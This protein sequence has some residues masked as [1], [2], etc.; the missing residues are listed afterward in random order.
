M[1]TTYCCRYSKQLF[2]LAD[3]MGP[4]ASSFVSEASCCAT[5]VSLLRF[6]LKYGSGTEFILATQI[7]LL[8]ADD[9]GQAVAYWLL[10]L[11][12]AHTI[13]WSESAYGCK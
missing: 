9:L 13:L 6:K 5:K 11:L 12:L 10:L 8:D 4:P 7:S 2:N 1:Q 3:Q